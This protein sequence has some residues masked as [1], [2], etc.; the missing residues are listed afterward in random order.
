MWL[1]DSAMAEDRVEQLS[2][3]RESPQT[4]SRPIQIPSI[5]RDLLEGTGLGLGMS[6]E[7]NGRRP[8]AN[9]QPA[10]GAY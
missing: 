7:P 8:H 5:A 1:A 9:G 3:P 4:T 10:Y 2:Q 6:F